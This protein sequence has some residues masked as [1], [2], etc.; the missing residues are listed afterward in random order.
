MISDL[1]R[2]KVYRLENKF[3]SVEKKF[4]RIFNVTIFATFNTRK[5]LLSWSQ[6]S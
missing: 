3:M 4:L 5:K 1:Q 2:S 6:E